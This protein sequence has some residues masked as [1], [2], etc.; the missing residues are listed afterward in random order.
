MQPLETLFNILAIGLQLF[1][2]PMSNDLGH[3]VPWQCMFAL[4]CIN[5]YRYGPKGL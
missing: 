1:F 4:S 5:Y 2:K 3:A